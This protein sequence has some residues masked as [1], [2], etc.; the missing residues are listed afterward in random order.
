MY[1]SGSELS[2]FTSSTMG[3]Q[4]ERLG[5]E[6]I[7][8]INYGQS[9]P[10]WKQG[11]DSRLQARQGLRSSASP[12]GRHCRTQQR[13]GELGT[14]ELLVWDICQCGFVLII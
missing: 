4:D 8:N 5:K 11:Q 9:E 7:P 1:G 10:G 12:G 13:K 6:Y 14:V 3:K 2:Y